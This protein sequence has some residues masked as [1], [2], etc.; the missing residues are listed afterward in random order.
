MAAATESDNKSGL[1]PLIAVFGAITLLSVGIGWFIGSQIRQTMETRIADA[2]AT[3]AEAQAAEA[4]AKIAAE[5]ADREAIGKRPGRHASK[6]KSGEHANTGEASVA[7]ESAVDALFAAA[8]ETVKL[9]PIVANLGTSNDKWIRLE[10][11]VIFKK[12]VEPTS[13][14]EK[15]AIS[16]AIV[17]MLRSK[18]AD[19]LS[20]PS[21][22]LQ[23]REDL[24]DTVMISTGG[25]AS[26]AKILSLV[27]E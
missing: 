15:F 26:A 24:M 18:T 4:A 1:V 23:F 14:Q 7:N 13:E 22:Y 9:D 27:V 8:P 19:E 17:G 16:E 6:K 10:L 25:R 12:G 20:G 11:A 3:G 21:G 2:S 5:K